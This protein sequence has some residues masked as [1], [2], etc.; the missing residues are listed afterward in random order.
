[1]LYKLESLSQYMWLSHHPKLSC[2]LCR[3]ACV[4]REKR[5]RQTTCQE[6]IY[7]CHTY[8]ASCVN[9]ILLALTYFS[10]MMMVKWLRGYL[11]QC[12]DTMQFICNVCKICYFYTFAVCTAKYNKSLQKEMHPYTY[13]TLMHAK[14]IVINV[15]CIL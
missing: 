10:T 15:F 8:Y 2:A 9:E 13:Y 14:F 12:T 4:C 7:S 5:H 3:R 11:L 1:M 6:G